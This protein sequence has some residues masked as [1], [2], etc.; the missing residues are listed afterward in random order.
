MS[1]RK[2]QAKILNGVGMLL[3]KIIRTNDET[4]EYLRIYNMPTDKQASIR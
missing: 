4:V 1:L 2:R 3:I